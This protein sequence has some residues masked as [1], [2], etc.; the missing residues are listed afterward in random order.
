MCVDIHLPSPVVGS[1]IRVCLHVHACA[2]VHVRMC[3]HVYVCLCVNV[4][5]LCATYRACLEES[6]LSQLI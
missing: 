4:C 5:V 2:H 1:F 3:M 6:I